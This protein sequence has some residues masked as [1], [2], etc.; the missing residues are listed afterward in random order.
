MKILNETFID[1][2][3]K[4]MILFSIFGVIAGYSVF[5]VLGIAIGAQH[6][7]LPWLYYVI[8]GEDE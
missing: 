8:T 7:W 2:P 5:G 1:K 6:A 3:V 4:I